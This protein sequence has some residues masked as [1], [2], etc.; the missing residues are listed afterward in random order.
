MIARLYSVPVGGRPFR[1]LQKLQLHRSLHDG[2]LHASPASFAS[3]TCSPWGDDSGGLY[4]ID[5]AGAAEL[6]VD[7]GAEGWDA[8]AAGVAGDVAVVA[9]VAS[10]YS[11]YG[12]HCVDLS[13]GGLTTATTTNAFLTSV[14]TN[15]RGE[16]WVT[17]GWSWLDPGG[18][19]PGVQVY[20]PATCAADGAAIEMTLAPGAVAFH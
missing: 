2:H 10:D 7:L 17:A 13:T 3:S 11:A 5:P 14:A 4:A 19:V 9:A 8:V 20:D 12:V 15:D 6:L 18:E 1:C 16:A